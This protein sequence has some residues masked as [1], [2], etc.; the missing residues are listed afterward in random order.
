MTARQRLIEALDRH[1]GR[2]PIAA[3]DVAELVRLLLEV[4][5]EDRCV[6]ARVRL[7]CEGPT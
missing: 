2:A 4:V 6:C 3:A 5:D 7:D 1:Q